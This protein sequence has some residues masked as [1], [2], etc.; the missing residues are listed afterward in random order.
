MRENGTWGKG[1]SERAEERST[2]EKQQQRCYWVEVGSGCLCDSIFF[3]PL[4]AT[5]DLVFPIP[6]TVTSWRGAHWGGVVW[7]P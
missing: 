4:Q 2:F 6:A 7:S 1:G 5:S 3:R